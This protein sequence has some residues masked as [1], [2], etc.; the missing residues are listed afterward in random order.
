[1]SLQRVLV[2]GGRPLDV[3][4]LERALRPLGMAVEGAE[5]HGQPEPAACLL[6][7]ADAVEPGGDDL[8]RRHRSAGGRV[9][10]VTPAST[11]VDE[12]SALLLDAAPPRARSTREPAP[13]HGGL[14]AREREILLHLSRGARN[15]D[16]ADDLGISQHTVRTHVQ[17]LLQK[18]GVDN[19]L[20]AAVSAHRNGLL[21]P[22][23]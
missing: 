20:E 11:T 23:P 9:V 18:L 13:D 3:A 5:P 4:V 6:L 10:A 2:V 21:A 14:T 1:M 12:L 16:I 7:L 19:R 17:N 8:V 22:A 15:S